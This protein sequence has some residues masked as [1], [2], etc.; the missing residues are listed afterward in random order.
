M[1]RPDDLLV[2]QDFERLFQE[3]IAAR[4]HVLHRIL[5]HDIGR[6]SASDKLPAIGEAHLLGADSAQQTRKH[7]IRNLLSGR[8]RRGDSDGRD[9]GLRRRPGDEGFGGVRRNVVDENHGRDNQPP[10]TIRR[11][12]ILFPFGF[13]GGPASLVLMGNPRAGAAGQIL[14]IKQTITLCC[15][16]R[17]MDA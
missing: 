2:A 14:G 11:K 1:R 8:T 15:E 7:L 3:G 17:V 6:N 4:K 9:M 10:V 5:H 13:G 16:S 12:T